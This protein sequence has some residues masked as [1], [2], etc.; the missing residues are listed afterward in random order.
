M[1]MLQWAVSRWQGPAAVALEQ[2]DAPDPQWAH[3]SDEEPRPP[4]ERH[5]QVAET[6]AFVAATEAA[7]AREAKA[8]EALRAKKPRQETEQT[9]GGGNGHLAA[10]GA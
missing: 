8:V 1:S 3:C 6:R 10:A 7:Y 4:R 9:V 5:V 2:P